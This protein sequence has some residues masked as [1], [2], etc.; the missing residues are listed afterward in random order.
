MGIKPTGKEVTLADQKQR[1][2]DLFEWQLELPQADIYDEPVRYYKA[3]KEW[4]PILH[5]LLD[6]LAD[7]AP[8]ADAEDESYSGIQ[9]M[10]KYLVGLDESEGGII[11]TTPQE[12]EKAVCDGVVCAIERISARI[13]SGQEDNLKGAIEVATSG[14]ISLRDALS[15]GGSVDIEGVTNEEVLYGQASSVGTGFRDLVNEVIGWEADGVSIGSI[16]SRMIQFYLPI[17]SVIADDA[18]RQAFETDLQ[19]EITAATANVTPVPSVPAIANLVYCN[20][21][22]KKS[23]YRYALD[24]EESGGTDA[25]EIA[26]L[27]RLIID[28]LDDTQLDD[29]YEDPSAIPDVGFTNAPC[30]KFPSTGMVVTSQDLFNENRHFW[31]TQYAMP[32]GV[33]GRRVRVE[34]EGGILLTD[35]RIFNGFQLTGNNAV[36]NIDTD[37]QWKFSINIINNPG[38]YTVIGNKIVAELILDPN[39]GI[40]ENGSIIF[41]TNNGGFRSDIDLSNNDPSTSRLVCRLVDLGLV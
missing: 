11:V 19:T 41:A 31:E 38:D 10:L 17:A 25:L 23:L 13:V 35:G 40:I 3:N 24:V 5:G 21:N 8:W 39:G 36:T 29:W 18:I 16:V 22:N 34:V 15:Q 9:Q 1:I 20:G 14:A 26:N 4:T 6:W 37:L 32:A 2:L 12:L 28:N 7:V 30:Y 33:N 27:Y